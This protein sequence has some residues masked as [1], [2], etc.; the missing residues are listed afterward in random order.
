MCQQ[1]GNCY[2]FLRA[3]T[4]NNSMMHSLLR[5]NLLVSPFVLHGHLNA[6]SLTLTL[7]LT[8]N[9]TLTV[10][11]T[12]T[13]TLP[14]TLTLTLM[15]TL[16]LGGGRVESSRACAIQAGQANGSGIHPLRSPCCKAEA[17]STGTTIECNTRIIFALIVEPEG[18]RHL[19]NPG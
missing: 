18:P 10:T 19:D 7:T 14:L 15:L 13:L 12:L 1:V 8:L 9:L 16:T 11:L 4:N 2:N 5:F 17:I 3:Q 6:K